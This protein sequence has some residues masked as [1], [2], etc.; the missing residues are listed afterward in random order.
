MERGSNG[1]SRLAASEAE[2]EEL[3]HTT[4]EKGD[5]GPSLAIDRTGGEGPERRRSNAEM[6]GS[7]LPMP[8]RKDAGPI[9][10][11]DL[12]SAGGPSCPASKTGVEGPGFDVPNV[13]EADPERPSD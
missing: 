12:K 10:A 5:D 8:L 9:C 4:P 13:E 1:N 2:E 11:D 7:N 6:G 3:I